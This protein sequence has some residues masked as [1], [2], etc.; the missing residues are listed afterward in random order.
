MTRHLAAFDAYGGHPVARAVIAPPVP[1]ERHRGFSWKDRLL[2]AAGVA[3][4]YYIGAQIGL[5]LT[6]APSTTSLLWPPNAVLTAALLLFPVRVWWV[7]LAA[8][9]P[10]HMLI[11]TGAGF[12]P[13][14]AALLF[15]TNCSEALI[16]AGTLRLVS[17]APTRFDTLR[18]VAWFIGLVGLAAPIISS[19]ADGAVVAMVRGEHF[20]DVWFKRVFANVLTELS[21]VPAVILGLAAFRRRQWPS[22]LRL[23]EL[24]RAVR[25]NRARRDHRLWRSANHPSLPW[26]AANADGA[27]APMVFLGGRTIRRRRRQLGTTVVGARRH[28]LDGDG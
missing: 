8:A 28:V 22:R 19:F 15:L 27:V 4:L 5:L 25:R 11:E 20:W 7:C 12:S 2:M 16:A 13:L 23:F 6:F 24:R 9:F 1:G 10:V 17:D 18:R 26:S 14:L 21:I 3:A